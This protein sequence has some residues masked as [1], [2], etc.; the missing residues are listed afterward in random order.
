MQLVSLNIAM[1]AVVTY[2]AQSVETGIYKEAVNGPLRLGREQLEG[3]GQ[4]DRVHH[5]GPDKAICVYAADHYPYWRDQLGK[6][7][8]YGAFGENFT[9]TG[10]TEDQVHIGDIF[11][12]GSAKVQVTQPRQPCYKLAAKHEVKD[13]ALQVQDTG[14]TGY[15][16]RVIEE[17]TVEA[18]QAVQLLER[19]PLGISVAEANRLQYR[20]KRDYEGIRRLLEVEALSDSWRESFEKR[21]E[22]AQEEQ[23]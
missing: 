11:A 13:L 12:V 1:P 10:W 2:G 15:Y 14:Y 6:E 7:L 20:D 17:G 4:G 23:G 18:R 9:V 3:D 22:A 19:H 16:F 8:P 21:L 5:G